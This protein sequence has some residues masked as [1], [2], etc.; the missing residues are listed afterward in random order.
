MAQ[1]FLKKIYKVSLTIYRYVVAID[2]TTLETFCILAYFI[3]LKG[4]AQLYFTGLVQRLDEKVPNVGHQVR[5][6][7]EAVGL[8]VL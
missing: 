3:G 1:F 6:A 2:A 4:G 5:E 7:E 8:R